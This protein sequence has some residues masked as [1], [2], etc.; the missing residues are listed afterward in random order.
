M[1]GYF[2]AAAVAGQK[3]E[4]RPSQ[5]N[6][7]LP[8]NINTELKFSN[9][10]FRPEFLDIIASGGTYILVQDTPESFPFSRHQLTTDVTSIETRE[11]SITTAIDFFAKFLRTQ[12][13]P[14]IGRFNITDNYLAQIKG[15]AQAAAR[16]TVFTFRDLR[17]IKIR[18]IEQDTDQPDTIILDLDIT[19]LFPANFI[20]VRLFI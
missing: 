14:F 18:K 13:K 11:F 9:T 19:P 7:N 6:T 5:P 12:L 3:S 8:L 17:E 16:K 15:V 20:R 10:Y 2:L 1:P 4:N